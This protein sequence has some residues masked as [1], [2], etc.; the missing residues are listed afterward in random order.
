MG[1]VPDQQR[2]LGG[3]MEFL[4]HFQ[5]LF[6]LAGRVVVPVSRHAAKMFSHPE[7]PQ[8]L[9]KGVVRVGGKNRLRPAALRDFF[10]Q[11]PR[12]GLQSACFFSFFILHDE[13]RAGFLEGFPAPVKA[14]GPVI[15]FHRKIKDLLITLRRQFRQPPSPQ[16]AVHDFATQPGIIQQ[17]AV[18]VPDQVAVRFQNHLCILPKDI[19]KPHPVSCFPLWVKR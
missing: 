16:L 10:Q 15:F 13:L 14:D 17:G 12:T 1:G 19:R 5:P 3:N 9:L 6:H 7:M 8:K 11:F 2:F 4:K 18:P